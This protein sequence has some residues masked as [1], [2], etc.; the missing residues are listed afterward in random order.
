[1][2]DHLFPAPFTPL[3]HTHIHTSLSSPHP[4]LHTHHSTTPLLLRETNSPHVC[5]DAVSANTAISKTHFKDF[6]TY[7]V[8]WQPGPAGYIE[9]YM[10]D[11]LLYSIQGSALNLTGSVIPEEPM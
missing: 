9:W 1:M 7:K 3:R 6:H 10:D 8:E 5:S 11:A 2:I 4:A